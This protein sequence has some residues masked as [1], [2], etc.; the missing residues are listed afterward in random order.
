MAEYRREG[1]FEKPYLTMNGIAMLLLLIALIAVELAGLAL[2]RRG[3]VI[4][5]IGVAIAIGFISAG[6]FMLQPNQAGVLTLF[7]DYLGTERKAGLRW[8]LPWNIR[9]RL[10]VRARCDHGH[11]AA[12]DQG[13]QSRRPAS[14]DWRERGQGPSGIGGLPLAD[15]MTGS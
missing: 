4:P 10:S 11:P 8:T 15:A 14:R 2:I 1:T 6:F 5:A 7:G 9:R 13:S 3:F 12:T